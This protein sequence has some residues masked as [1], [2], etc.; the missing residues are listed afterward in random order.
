MS[1]VFL[2]VIFH[3]FFRRANH[4]KGEARNLDQAPQARLNGGICIVPAVPTQKYIHFVG[5]GEGDVRG[6]AVGCNRRGGIGFMGSPIETG[7]GC[8]RISPF[9]AAPGRIF[10]DIF[11][12]Q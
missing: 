1:V 5:A 8:V 9:N 4:G 11:R 6:V 7:G 10:Q 3:Q 2:I 12:P